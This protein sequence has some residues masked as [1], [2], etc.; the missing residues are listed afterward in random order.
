[1]DDSS[2]K[3]DNFPES[4]FPKD[5]FAPLPE[6]PEKPPTKKSKRNLNETHKLEE[7]LAAIRA[8]S[9]KHDATFLKISTIEKTTG[10]TK[11]KVDKLADTVQQLIVDVNQQKEAIRCMEHEIKG[12]KTENCTLKN[13]I[14][15]CQRYSRRWSLKVHG[16]KEKDG[17][18]SKELVTELFAKV[19]PK[20]RD[21][22]PRG[23]DI[24]HRLGQRRQNGS[25]RAII[26]LF[27]LRWLRDAVWREA[28][29]CTF[30]QDNKLRIAEALSTEDKTAREKLWPMVK[31]AREEGKRASF[32]GPFAFIDGKRLD[33]V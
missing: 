29:D 15:D 18:N 33:P 28:K 2:S 4:E 22:L 14:A 20:F 5:P 10:S 27:A 13:A 25:H 7:M 12:L 8:L 30:L 24:V 23:I 19:A 6:T 11:E 9:M 21:S 1:M 32:R 26:V 17:E 3:V 16:V 31:K